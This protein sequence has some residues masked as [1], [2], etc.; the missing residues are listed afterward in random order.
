MIERFSKH[1]GLTPAPIEVYIEFGT[2][3]LSGPDEESPH[4]G[5]P[6]V[7]LIRLDRKKD[8][9][10]GCYVRGCSEASQCHSSHETADLH[11][12]ILFSPSTAQRAAVSE[13]WWNAGVAP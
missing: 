11:L 2:A 1:P 9:V 4:D 8:I 7:F 13:N 3:E 5:G 10:S 6:Q 12:I